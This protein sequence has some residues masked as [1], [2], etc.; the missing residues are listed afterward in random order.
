[1]DIER[2][3]K[4][5]V[6][7]MYL[8][9]C[10][11]H[12]RV[13]EKSKLLDMDINGVYKM[14]KRHS[15]QAIVYL[16]YKLGLDEYSD[17]DPDRELLARWEK[18]YKL[19]LHK[20]VMLDVERE[21]LC[22]FLKENG[23][24]YCCLKGVVLQNYYPTLGM[25][26]M[27]DNDILVD[28][29]GCAKIRSF[30]TSRGYEV[31]HYGSGCHDVYLKGSLDFEIHRKLF[32]EGTKTYNGSDYYR[33]VKNMLVK[34]EDS[35]ELYFTDEEFYVY[36]MCHAYK[37]FS[38]GGC[39]IRTLLDIFLYM[40]SMEKKLDMDAVNKSLSSIGIAEYEKKSRA[41]AFELV[42]QRNLDNKDYGYDLSS[43]N[44][45]LFE[46]YI[47]SGTYGTVE[48]SINNRL[49]NMSKDDE[50]SDGVKAK[51]LFRRI[52]PDMDYYRNAYPRASKIY[53]IIPFLWLM[54]LFRGIGR[55]KR[56][57][58]EVR[59]VNKTEK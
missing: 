6:D 37:H 42:S 31:E 5:G 17:I 44:R 7:T 11:L 41:L 50:I 55:S 26:Q 40:S 18:D 45:S 56:Y 13:P 38:D 1:M 30:M 51:Y 22:N 25:R 47:T 53:P 21:A 15:M 12:N 3:Y 36:Y 27:A 34:K 49:S 52:F 35:C 28:T 14:A 59:Q 33:N 54:R 29:K 2:V 10:A 24:W 46:Y 58:K 20:L 32:P 4:I 19:C 48:R 9:V 8:A 16:G 23:I 43:E 57:M 39:G